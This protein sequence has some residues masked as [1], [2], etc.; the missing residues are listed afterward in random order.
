MLYNVQRLSRVA[1]E[2]H[3]PMVSFSVCDSIYG[4]TNILDFKGIV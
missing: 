2:Q 3:C 4:I 1:I